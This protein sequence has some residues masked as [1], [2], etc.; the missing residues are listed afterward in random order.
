MFIR[1]ITE[2]IGTFVL[3]SVIILS[4]EAIP[5]AIALGAMIY[6]GGKISKAHY[7]PAV[8]TMLYAKGDIDFFTFITYVIA[9]LSAGLCAFLW[10]R[11]AYNKNNI[12][13]LGI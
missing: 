11:Y 10:H 3:L 2:F 13:K 5:I 8:S 7:N 4:G 6:F 12:V 9:Q 1:L